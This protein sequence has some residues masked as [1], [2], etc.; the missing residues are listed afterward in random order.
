MCRLTF[1]CKRPRKRVGTALTC[2]RYYPGKTKTK[3]QWGSSP[4][5]EVRFHGGRT[6]AQCTSPHSASCLD[7]TDC[8][9]KPQ[10]P[11][12]RLFAHGEIAFHDISKCR[13]RCPARNRPRP[14]RPSCLR[15]SEGELPRLRER[16]A[17]DHQ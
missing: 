16:R 10:M 8:A 11:T 4:R 14:E 2:L 7:D 3:K 1:P 13:S 9:L 5:N 6:G 17:A 15:P 12:A